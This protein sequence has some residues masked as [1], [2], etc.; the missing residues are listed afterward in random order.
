MF[1]TDAIRNSKLQSS[2]ISEGF[3]PKAFQSRSA[4]QCLKDFIKQMTM[5][6]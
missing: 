3:W 1:M 2:C 4:K 5:K 6:I